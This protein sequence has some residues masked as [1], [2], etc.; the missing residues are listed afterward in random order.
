MSLALLFPR[1]LHPAIEERFAGW[2]NEQ[3]I[4]RDAPNAEVH[5]YDP[6][7]PLS[8]ALHGIEA[9][10]VLVVTDPLLVPS[11]RLAKRLVKALDDQTTAAAAVPVSNE[12]AYPQQRVVSPQ[13]YLTLSQFQDVAHQVAT[14]V[15]TEPPVVSW[16]ASNP[17][18]FVGRTQHFLQGEVLPDKALTGHSVTIDTS[19][20][21]HRFP[22]HRGQ[23]RGDLLERID[24]NA[25]TILEFGCGEAALG[26]AL[27][28]R[29]GARVIG[30][31]MDPDAA[32]VARKRIDAVL[33]GDVLD[34]IYKLKENF[35]WI[36][37]GDILEHLDEPWS[38]LMELRKV[39][40]PGGHLILS[41]PNVA[42]WPIISDLLRGRFDYVYMGILCAGHLRFFTR[43]SIEEMLNISGWTVVSIEPQPLFL[44]TE[45]DDLL[46]KLQSAG[47]EY[48][49]SDLA[50]PGYYVIA[51][52]DQEPS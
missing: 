9:D 10:M 31:E 40:A 21:V 20:Y 28:A 29:Q 6:T 24:P 34:V 7:R 8:K 18:V 37:G 52:N 35:D 36:V 39:A 50:T 49:E 26:A 33:V 22:S 1:F 11:P 27:K 4:R 23:M 16:D 44:T 13:L 43:R 19:T 5:H 46:S 38:F 15:Q 51:R 47:I 32:A 2:Q 12:S 30:I 17:G 41:L 3:L 42:S 48:S 25:K 45:F 14:T